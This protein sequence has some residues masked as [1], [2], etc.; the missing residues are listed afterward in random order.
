MAL[1]MI[2]A[3]PFLGDDGFITN[4]EEIIAML[5]KHQVKAAVCNCT[6]STE[7]P[8]AHALRHFGVSVGNFHSLIFNYLKANPQEHKL[9]MA[10][11]GSEMLLFSDQDVVAHLDTLKG[12]AK[13]PGTITCIELML[14]A[15][16]SK[17]HVAVVFQNSVWYSVPFDSDVLDQKAAF[18]AT[19]KQTLLPAEAKQFQHNCT[20]HWYDQSNPMFQRGTVTKCDPYSTASKHPGESSDSDV[21]EIID[22]PPKPAQNPAAASLAISAP[23]PALGSGVPLIK[24]PRSADDP[25]Y[26]STVSTIMSHT[27]TEEELREASIATLTAQLT[28]YK[29]SQIKE[30]QEY[31]DSCEE[32]IRLAKEEAEDMVQAAETER[33]TAL[34]RYEEVSFHIETLQQALRNIQQ[35]SC[36][37]ASDNETVRLTTPP[38]PAMP[39]RFNKALDRRVK[40]K[41]DELTKQSK[42]AARVDQKEAEDRLIAKIVGNKTL[43]TRILKMLKAQDPTASLEEPEEQQEQQQQQQAAITTDEAAMNVGNEVTVGEDTDAPGNQDDAFI[44]GFGPK[45]ARMQQQ[46]SKQ[47][48]EQCKSPS[49]AQRV[50]VKKGAKPKASKASHKS[51]AGSGPQVKFAF[52]HSIKKVTPTVKLPE[53]TSFLPLDNLDSVKGWKA[54]GQRACPIRSCQWVVASNEELSA[55]VNIQH[56]KLICACQEFYF[57]SQSL[58]NHT[59]QCV[60]FAQKQS[61]PDSSSIPKGTKR[62]AP[63]QQTSGQSKKAKTDRSHITQNPKWEPDTVV[64]SLGLTCSED[65]PDEEMWNYDIFDTDIEGKPVCPCGT[66]LKDA[67]GVMYHLT[68][69]TDKYI[70]WYCVD[71][72]LNSKHYQ[73]ARRGYKD[74]TRHMVK[75]HSFPEKG[76][77]FG[78]GFALAMHELFKKEIGK[79]PVKERHE[80]VQSWLTEELIAE[81]LAAHTA[82]WKKVMEEATA[83]NPSGSQTPTKP[84]PKPTQA[85]AP[86]PTPVSTPGINVTA[87]ALTTTA[88]SATALTTVSTTAAASTSVTAPA[89]ISASTTTVTSIA[90]PLTAT[91]TVHAPASGAGLS[92]LPQTSQQ[93]ASL[94]NAV[95][96]LIQLRSASDQEPPPLTNQQMDALLHGQPV[97]G[98]NP[99]GD[100]SASGTPTTTE[101]Q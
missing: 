21:C 32:R 14:F 80:A 17:I 91:A 55:H 47:E 8:T 72:N 99:T 83:S 59:K 16:I 20:L 62:S 90:T 60:A 33:D 28:Q 35:L 36:Q 10:N 34:K 67:E 42:A 86:I 71:F 29:A 68:S 64:D 89:N 39:D 57:H 65:I 51:K 46:L 73:E 82:A 79:L 74:I 13:T 94:M 53:G 93:R 9:L 61:A 88:A 24:L 26:V 25:E 70:C 87:S 41:T 43:R 95:T 96:G 97:P 63:K 100:S 58:H 52:G 69:H 11:H 78:R 30:V 75:V 66:S 98:S 37:A 49:P 15:V 6:D 4:Q 40:A 50:Q 2:R 84:D 5:K 81:T 38:L 23:A 54:K 101:Q 22:P 77:P 48:A 7:D 56:S 12:K 45:S 44:P 31:K 27:F 1:Q 19:G 92:N 85:P 18:I 3:L 76:M